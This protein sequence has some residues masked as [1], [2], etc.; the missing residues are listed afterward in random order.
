[1][2]P[3]FDKSALEDTLRL[4]AGTATKVEIPFQ[5]HPAPTVTWRFKNGDLPDSRRFKEDTARGKTIL[6][7]SKVRD[8]EQIPFQPDACEQTRYKPREIP[9]R[10]QHFEKNLFSCLFAT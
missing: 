2:A 6:S 7:M 1:M 8:D 5:G 4:H 9:E 3:S 10:A